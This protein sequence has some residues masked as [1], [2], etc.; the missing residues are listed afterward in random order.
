MGM[1]ERLPFHDIL[2]LTMVQSQGGDEKRTVS[3]AVSVRTKIETMVRSPSLCF[4]GMR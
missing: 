2:D 3:S 4:G 1:G